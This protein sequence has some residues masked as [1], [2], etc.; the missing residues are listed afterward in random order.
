M[1]SCSFGATRAQAD[2]FG[3][4]RQ[5]GGFGENAGQF[6]FPAALAVDPTDNSVYTL[7]APGAIQRGAGPVDFRVQ[8][9]ASSL[10]S[11][12]ATLDLATPAVSGH[13][14][15]IDDIAIDPALHRLYVLVGLE[16][17]RPL[18]VPYVA[19]EIDAYSTEASGQTLPPAPGVEYESKAGVFYRFAAV[20]N[21]GSLPS[22]AVLQPH[23]LA[24]DPKNHDLLLLG[25]DESQNPVIQQIAT[26]TPYSSGSVGESFDDLKHELTHAGGP[27]SAIAVAAD[28]TLYVTSQ[29]LAAGGKGV[30]SVSIE[31]P[32]SLANPAIGLLASN[33]VGESNAL[34]GGVEGTG[35]KDAGAQVAVSPESNG[36]IYATQMNKEQEPGSITEEGSYEV[37]GMNEH[38]ERQVVLGGG[39]GGSS[40]RCHIASAAS[41]IGVGSGGVV[42]ALDEGE[43]GFN[44][45]TEE[46]EHSSYGF[47]LLEFGPNGSGCPTPS[48]SFTINGTAAS[49]TVTVSKGSIVKFD[50]SGSQLNGEEPVELDWDLDG[51]GKYATVVTGSPASLE[52]SLKYLTPGHYTVGLRIGLKGGGSFGDPPPVS[53][54]LIVEPTPPIARL[55]VFPSSNLGE[56]LGIGQE[57]KPGETIT[58]SGAESVDPTG[59]P[60]G[61]PV[62]TLKEYVW[63]FGDGET[64]TTTTPSDSRSFVNTATTS[65]SETVSLAVRN[66]EGVESVVTAMQTIAVQ[67]VAPTKEP[68]PSIP[69][70]TP[71]PPS[72]ITTPAPKTAPPTKKP[73]TA[74]QK[75]AKALKACKK[76]KSKRA[77]T[78]CERTAHKRYGPKPKKKRKK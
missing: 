65:R 40:P 55:E 33:S 70:G 53:G 78:A 74:A 61:G 19:E 35:K 43:T 44:E 41:A 27:A 69:Q 54:T 64:K 59:S 45:E 25:N 6:D 28:G 77:R 2:A 5:V 34:T 50:A 8:K 23:G 60:T 68:E 36:L 32:N 20:P 7:D 14:Q 42:Y 4:L 71:T 10:G 47:R 11:P 57:V 46:F 63:S 52:T 15:V 39:A 12:A 51:S 29:K 9:F 56:P 18:T 66:E 62:H 37:R 76:V 16:V 31:S 26:V 49:T 24:V 1:A 30:E 75:L 22:G 38:G 48:A 21:T 58:F 72:T 17:E 67:G 3:E 73:L 13:K